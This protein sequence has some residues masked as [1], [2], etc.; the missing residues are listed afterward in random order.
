MKKE[1]L[2]LIIGCFAVI[3]LLVGVVVKEYVNQEVAFVKQNN[4]KNLYETDAYMRP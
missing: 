1:K 3:G 4:M 2:A